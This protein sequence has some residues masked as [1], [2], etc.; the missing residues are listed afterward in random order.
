MGYDVDKPT[1]ADFQANLYIASFANR[2]IYEQDAYTGD[3]DT[4]AAQ[5][6]ALAPAHIPVATAPYPYVHEPGDFYLDT[7]GYTAQA[8]AAYRSQAQLGNLT[9][10][11]GYQIYQI[12]WMLPCVAGSNYSWTTNQIIETLTA[13]TITVTRSGI[14]EPVTR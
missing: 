6:T 8:V 5:Y 9:F 1:E 3:Y 4:C 12:M 11:C 7:N 13:T 2:Q 10:P 14:G